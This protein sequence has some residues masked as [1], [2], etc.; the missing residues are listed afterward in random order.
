MQLV[1]KKCDVWLCV[2]QA[3]TSAG[4]GDG[5][6]AIATANRRKVSDEA[7]LLA[8]TTGVENAYGEVVEGETVS[9]A[10]LPSGAMQ[11]GKNIS[12]SLLPVCVPATWDGIVDICHSFYPRVLPDL[13]RHL[14]EFRTHPVNYYESLA[15]VRFLTVKN[16]PSRFMDDTRFLA[17]KTPRSAWETRL[18]LYCELRLLELFV[19]D[20][21]TSSGQDV[22]REGFVRLR[23]FVCENVLLGPLLEARVGAVL[24][25]R[26][27]LPAHLL[28]VQS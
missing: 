6:A 4:T 14:D 3:N 15:G 9:D 26:V 13:I 12:N 28:G 10:G 18:F 21:Y 7:A 25:L 17:L 23:E 2:F 16:S 24:K 22:N 11:V 8:S 27:D 5:S 1:V 19:G 20:G